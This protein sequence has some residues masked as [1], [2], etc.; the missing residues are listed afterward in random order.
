M[1]GEI[2]ELVIKPNIELTENEVEEIHQLVIECFFTGEFAEQGKPPT[3]EETKMGMMGLDIC[4]M[5]LM[6]R[7]GKIVGMAELY[8]DLN[9]P[10]LK[11][12]LTN[13]E[14]GENVCSMGVLKTYRRRRIATRI[15]LKIIEDFGGQMDLVLNVHGQRPNTEKLIRFYKSAGFTLVLGIEDDPEE[16]YLRWSPLE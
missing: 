12:V 10:D 14:I 6:K 4:L 15:L 11:F 2:E 7:D 13:K 8:N 1:V 9:K 3:L 16:Y 5:Y